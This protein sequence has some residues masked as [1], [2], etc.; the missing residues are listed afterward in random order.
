MG[1]R[2]EQHATLAVYTDDASGG[3]VRRG[4]EDGVRGDAIA[5]EKRVCVSKGA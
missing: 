3:L 1:K 5:A 2:T 4:D